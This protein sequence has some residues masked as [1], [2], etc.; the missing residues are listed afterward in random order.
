[1][2]REIIL[3]KRNERNEIFKYYQY[4]NVKTMWKPEN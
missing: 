3:L 4:N 1:M 2:N